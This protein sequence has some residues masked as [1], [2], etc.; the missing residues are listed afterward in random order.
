MQTSR[1]FQPD[2]EARCSGAGC[3]LHLG[4]GWGVRGGLAQERRPPHPTK[5]AKGS[6]A[7]RHISCVSREE[8]LPKKAAYENPQH[9]S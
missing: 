1:C 6:A 4:T 3:P 2:P 7:Q 5:Q 8:A 9:S